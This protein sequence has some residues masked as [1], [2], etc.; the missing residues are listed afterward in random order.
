M[1]FFRD[2]GKGL[3]G[4]AGSVIGG[5]VKF[6]GEMT[7]V[8]TLE[9][10]GDGV[11]KA[12]TFAGDT[13]GQVADGTVNTVSGIWHDDERQRDSG[14]NDIGD[15]VLRTGKGVYHTGKGIVHNGGHMIGGAIDGDMDAVKK[16]ASGLATTAAVGSLA[17]GIVDVIDG[18]D[19]VS[20]EG[21]DESATLQD[22]NSPTVNTTTSSISVDESV[23][24]NETNSTNPDTHEVK[25]HYVEGY[26][27]ADG[28]VVDGYWRDGDGDSSTML[29]EEE[30][31]G[32]SRSNPDGNPSNNLK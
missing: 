24:L 29:K 2:V 30:G 18:A 17:V 22:S 15:A 6:V 3:G 5:P 19:S 28:T 32:Y 12:S 16:G 14:L 26:T 9:D 1:G 10:I 20:A 11:K 21:I 13:L 31:G 25:P 7:G 4:L 23:S 27:R 8:K